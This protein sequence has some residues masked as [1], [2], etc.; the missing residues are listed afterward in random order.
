MKQ[1]KIL[2]IT[3][4]LIIIVV[5]SLFYIPFSRYGVVQS[6]YVLDDKYI[7]EYSTKEYHHIYDIPSSE[8]IIV[9]P[10]GQI[11][12]VKLELKYNVIFEE[13]IIRYVIIITLLIIYSF[14]KITH[15]KQVINKIIDYCEKCGEQIDEDSLYCKYCGAETKIEQ[16]ESL[17]E[18]SKRM[19]MDNPIHVSWKKDFLEERNHQWEKYERQQARLESESDMKAGYK[20][21]EETK[22][23]SMKWFNFFT[24]ILM[25]M[26]LISPIINYMTIYSH[27]LE[28]NFT[29]S[30]YFSDSLTGLQNTVSFIM[31][32]L[33]ILILLLSFIEIHKGTDKAYKL[34]LTYF[35][36][37]I[38]N[39]I[40]YSLMYYQIGYFSLGTAIGRILGIL[41]FIIPNII[42]FK[43]RKHLFIYKAGNP[44]L[45]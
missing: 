42:Y 45:Y 31:N 39:Q 41:I 19:G 22:S 43:R 16:P 2:I 6:P 14:Y 13:F 9:K 40:I 12:F 8:F 4:F 36:Y 17:E 32:M 26:W 3:T 15:K 27:M 37:S 25:P 7:L 10:K 23:L 38:V 29:W 21:S 1:N 33:L 5:S 18:I 44:N 20:Q 24:V 35:I 28:N 11:N 34:L 30:D